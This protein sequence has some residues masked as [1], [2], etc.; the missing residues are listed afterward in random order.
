MAAMASN[1]FC[2]DA[3][4]EHSSEPKVLRRKHIS[5]FGSGQ[6]ETNE[7]EVRALEGATKAGATHAPGSVI[8]GIR[9]GN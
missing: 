7:V 6:F 9:V 1:A 3:K 2:S 8:G 5:L 4:R